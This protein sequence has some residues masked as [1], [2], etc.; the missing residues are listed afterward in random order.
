MKMSAREMAKVYASRKGQIKVTAVEF[1]LSQIVAIREAIS[2]ILDDGTIDD[3]I[4]PPGS[5]VRRPWYF[6]APDD[7]DWKR[8]TDESTADRMAFIDA[9]QE[10]LTKE[11]R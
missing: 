7:Y 5:N 11:K 2:T 6:Y 1:S 8:D 3:S 10:A 9:I 4:P